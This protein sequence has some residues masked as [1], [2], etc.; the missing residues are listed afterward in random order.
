MGGEWHDVVLGH[1]FS[2]DDI[3][4]RVKPQPREFWVFLEKDSGEIAATQTEKPWPETIKRNQ[5]NIIHCR[6]VTDAT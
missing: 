1:D 4:W 6:E 3:Q 2:R 5:F